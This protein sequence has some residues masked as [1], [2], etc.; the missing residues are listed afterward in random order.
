MMVEISVGK[1][2]VGQKISNMMASVV[3]YEQNADNF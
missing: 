1:R 2:H 3:H